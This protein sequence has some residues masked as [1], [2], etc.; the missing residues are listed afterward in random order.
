MA[1]MLMQHVNGSRPLRTEDRETIRA[2]RSRG[3]IYFDRN[4]RP[5]RSFVT[6]K[7]RE[8]VAELL[9]SQADRLISAKAG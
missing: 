1:L 8:V 7:G 4:V 6:V 9:A 3:L 2:L 5:T